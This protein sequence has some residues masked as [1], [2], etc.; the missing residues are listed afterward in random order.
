[1]K[2]LFLPPRVFSSVTTSQTR[3]ALGQHGHFGQYEPLLARDG[4]AAMTK[5]VNRAPLTDRHRL[6][7]EVEW[8]RSRQV[9]CVQDAAAGHCLTHV[10]HIVGQDRD[11]QAAIRL[12]PHAVA[13]G[14]PAPAS[15]KN[16]E[17]I[18]DSKN[19]SKDTS[20]ETPALRRADR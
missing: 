18:Q 6:W 11:P 19:T 20:E 17:P 8:S 12:R 13:R 7:S 5:E 10:E 15:A 3:M 4:E 9:W 16:R 14:S 1:M 2:I